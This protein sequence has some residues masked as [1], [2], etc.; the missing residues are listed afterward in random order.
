MQFRKAL[1]GFP[2]EVV[3][4][5]RE[6]LIAGD[7]ERGEAIIARYQEEVRSQLRAQ[8]I[9]IDS[10]V[11][12]IG[13]NCKWSEILRQVFRIQE[14]NRGT[15]TIGPDGRPK[16]ANFNP[17]GY[18]LVESPILNRLVRIPILHGDD[19]MLA[20]SL[21][22]DP[23][24]DEIIEEA[25]FLVTYAPKRTFFGGMNASTRHVLHY[26]LCPCGTLKRYYDFENDLHIRKPAPE[27]L[28]GKFV[29]SGEVS[30]RL[31]Q[32]PDVELLHV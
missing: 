10:V 24:C 28:F 14:F 20:G 31:N 18:L 12:E 19:Y 7:R 32:H 2:D 26:A 4:E 23:H 1:P 5:V 21:F 3:A 13:R 22:D 29:Y 6:A 11:L 25:E 9:D 16:A 27:K 8:G 30:V 15:I 17:Y